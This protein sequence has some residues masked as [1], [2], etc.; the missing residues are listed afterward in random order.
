MNAH[1]NRSHP[2]PLPPTNRE[3]PDFKD[4]DVDDP[5]TGYSA[6]PGNVNNLLVKIPSYAAVLAG[7]D[8]GVVDEFV[9]PK[10]KDDTRTTFKK[11][12]RLE[13]MMQDL[14]LLLTKQLGSEAKVGFTTM[15][16]WLT[17]SP[18]K[19]DPGA[20]ADSAAKGSPPGSPSSAEA[21]FY[22]A[23]LSILGAASGASIERAEP[24]SKLGIPVTLMPAIVLE[25][26]FAL[27]SEEVGEKF[28][29][30]KISSRSTLVVE[31]AGVE[32]EDLE[33]DGA[34]VIKVTNQN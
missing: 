15:Q 29:G 4:G 22:S 7:P 5:A 32:I 20:G 13:C 26:S 27:T 8:Q 24:V 3:S 30:G 14:P 10:Y 28:K 17:F 9:N 6:F 2:L 11:P 21:D 25:P 31:G 18:A 33:L 19:N 23:Y 1:H 12:T 34:L 16:R